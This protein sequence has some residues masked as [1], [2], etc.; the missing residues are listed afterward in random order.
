MKFL[1]KLAFRLFILLAV[2]VV[3]ALLSWDWIVKKVAEHR[4]SKVT[5][6]ETRIG[7]LEVGVASPVIHIENFK[8][9][10]P[11]EFGGAPLV[12][13]PEFHM[14]YDAAAL[15]GGKLRVKLLR[16]NLAELN[17][18]RNAA[19]QTNINVLRG[20]L[21]AQKTAASAPT[22]GSAGADKGGR[23]FEFEKIEMLN[24][25]LGKVRF[26]DLAQATNSHEWVLD[27]HNQAFANV[28]SRE[29]IYGMAMVL[30][31]KCGPEMSEQLTY[32]LRNAAADGAQ[33]VKQATDKARGLLK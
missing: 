12:D 16:L 5:G 11:A 19:G 21:E 22:S 32:Q 2:V 7:K 10:N 25:T 1:F 18:V 15:A 4:I 29:D 27:V 9:Y 24:L 14:E 13:I 6:M 20:R 30:L 8:L 33:K 17:L 3:V 31:M 26:T 28:K 23:R